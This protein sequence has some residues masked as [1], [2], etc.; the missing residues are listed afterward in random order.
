VE[1]KSNKNTNIFAGPKRGLRGDFP[2]EIGFQ[3]ASIDSDSSPRA[4]SAAGSGGIDTPHDS[5]RYNR[6]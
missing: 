1:N 3:P 6:S 5:N 4:P 2:A